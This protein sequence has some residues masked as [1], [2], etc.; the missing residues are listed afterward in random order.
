M[1]FPFDEFIIIE[2][3][4]SE[5]CFHIMF[6]GQVSTWS[7]PHCLS[8]T[9]FYGLKFFTYLEVTKLPDPPLSSRALTVTGFGL[10]FLV[11]KHKKAMGL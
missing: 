11:F 9:M 6:G 2:L 7:S 8:L 10:L 1:D 3:W 5:F 4:D